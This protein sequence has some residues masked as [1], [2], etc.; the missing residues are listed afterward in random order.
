MGSDRELASFKLWIC[1]LGNARVDPLVLA[2]VAPQA[3]PVGLFGFPEEVESELE[4][5][6]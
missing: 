1:G 4:L 5:R 2:D 3:R 6:C